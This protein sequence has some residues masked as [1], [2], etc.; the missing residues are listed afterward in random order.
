MKFYDQCIQQV[1]GLKGSGAPF[2]SYIP[3]TGTA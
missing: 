3:L 1:T 2:Q